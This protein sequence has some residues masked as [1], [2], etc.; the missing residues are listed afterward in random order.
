M[1]KEARQ[2]V[3]GAINDKYGKVQASQVVKAATPKKSPIHNDFEWDDAIAANQQRLDTARRIIKTTVLVSP[4]GV[5]EVF[6]HVPPRVIE[7]PTAA[8]VDREGCYKTIAQVLKDPEEYVR[9]L[10]EL[11]TQVRGIERTIRMVKRVAG[12]R[13]KALLPALIDSMHV[14]RSTV[15]LMLDEAA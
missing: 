4:T 7:G 1:S 9:A 2:K 11:Q 14:A 12:D 6:I 8:D 15:K 10:E 3:L 13:G 5:R